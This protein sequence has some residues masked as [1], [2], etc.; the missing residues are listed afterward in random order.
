MTQFEPTVPQTSEEGRPPWSS[1]PEELMEFINLHGSAFEPENDAYKNPGPFVDAVSHSK[2]SP[3]YQVHTYHTK[4][5]PQGIVEYIQH[6]TD[7]G[8][9]VLDPFCGSGMT[10]VACLMTGRHSVLNDLSPAATHIAYNYCEP[11]DPNSLTKEWQAIREKVSSEFEWLYG[12]KC[13]RCGGPATIQ[14]VVWSDV[15]ECLGCR[16]ELILWNSA[17]VR[18]LSSTGYS[19]PL[20][21]GVTPNPRVWHPATVENSGSKAG[22]GGEDVPRKKGDVLDQFP[23]HN[24][25]QLW[26]KTQLPLLRTEPVLTNAACRQ[27]KPSKY[28]Y[29]ITTEEKARINDVDQADIPYWVPDAPFSSD[30]EMWRGGHRKLGINNVKDFWTKRNLRSLGNLFDAISCVK[31]E[32]DR[33]LLLFSVTAC[34]HRSARTTR[35]KGGTGSDPLMGTLYVGSFTVENN[36]LVM[37]DRRIKVIVETLPTIRLNQAPSSEYAGASAVVTQHAG[38]RLPLP[39]SCVD[40]VFTDPPFGSNLFYSDLN[41]LWESWLGHLTDDTHE[42]VWNKSKKKAQGGKSLQDYQELMKDAF[43]EMRRVLKPGRWASVVFHNSD[44]KIWD[45]IRD[46]AGEAGFDIQNAQ[47]FDKQQKTFKGIRGAKGLENVS[48][49]DIVLNLYN[50]PSDGQNLGEQLSIG[51]PMRDE[52]EIDSDKAS[53]DIRSKV[54]DSIAVNIEAY[55]T[56]IGDYDSERP[57]SGQHPRGTQ[58]V[59][60]NIIQQMI[61]AGYPTTGVSLSHVE[62]VLCEFFK[63]VMGLWYLMGDE[64]GPNGAVLKPEDS[65]GADKTGVAENWTRELIKVVDERTTIAWIRAML[66]KGPEMQSIIK[67]QH[68]L[69]APSLQLVKDLDQ[70]L[71]E[72]FTYNSRRKHWRLPNPDEL[73][74]KSELRVKLLERRVSDV[75]QQLVPHPGNNELAN[76]IDQCYE[77]ELFQLTTQLFLLVG[78]GDLTEER[79][80][81]IARKN[82]ISEMRQ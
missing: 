43:V 4:V 82:R 29:P 22:A 42:A 80:K 2:S 75:L 6:Y 81:D 58:A 68:K 3:I 57:D 44:D 56:K 17:I 49:L 50:P 8:S 41:L 48:N 28:S 11:M 55:L 12:T 36:L 65:V 61:N 74:E 23:C 62:I 16:G 10:G 40:Y 1:S 39:D 59:H 9:V 37:L 25:G 47:A 34:M 67:N 38:Q 60:S 26:K 19:P 13:Q 5:P 33:S 14:S 30:R 66:S 72:N 63:D 79:Q 64:V 77:S 20:S 46:A 73:V 27:C 54:R 31:D 21:I 32:R 53:F 70:I 52:L 7:V 51:I 69:M 71:E 18:E 24:C 35:F 76:L 78:A 45:A 15:Y